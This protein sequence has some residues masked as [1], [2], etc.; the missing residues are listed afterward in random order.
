MTGKHL[1]LVGG[2]HAHLSILKQLR[3]FTS[4]GH[5]VTLVSPLP[6]HDYSGM[7]PGLLSGKHR[8]AE[9]RFNIARMT[10]IRGGRFIEAAAVAIDPVKK[11]INLSDGETI[12]YDVVSFNCGSEVTL[13]MPKTAIGKSIFPVK[14]IVNMFYV[15]QKIIEEARNNKKPL[16][17][18]VIGGGPAGCEVAGNL[19]ALSYDE[20]IHA[21]I[22]LVT[23]SCLLPEF[24]D[25]TRR[26]T[27][28]LLACHPLQLLEGAFINKLHANQADLDDKRTIHFDFAI[29][30]TGI[31]PPDF[32]SNSSLSDH[33]EGLL[34]NDDLQSP[35]FP[36]IFGGGDCIHR[37]SKPL[38]K[39]GVH[40]IRQSPILRHNL[41]A[42]LEGK[43]LQKFLPQ[44]QFLLIFNLGMG[45]AVATGYGISWSGFP[46]LLLKSHLDQSFVKKFQ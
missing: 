16:R 11:T 9:A 13:P 29:V 12:N 45:R 33:A 10:T 2:G 40:A 22:T 32:F 4:R 27:R 6:F 42:A 24:S 20:G 28:K 15:R 39:V 44:K 23:G 36:E 25:S 14:P 19:Q 34:V 46:A 26:T 37:Q 35:A 5:R 3:S 8:L 1:V 18:L 30:A 41:L 43:P 7:G 21:T 38:K 17:L 31:S